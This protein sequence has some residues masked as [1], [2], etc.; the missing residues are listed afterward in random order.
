MRDGS[1]RLPGT[2]ERVYEK[3]GFKGQESLEGNELTLDSVF[4][5]GCKWYSRMWNYGCKLDSESLAMFF[6]IVWTKFGF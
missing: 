3:G 6:Y 5:P 1:E 2:Q 4:H